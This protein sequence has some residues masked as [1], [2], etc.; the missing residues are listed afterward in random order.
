[1][2]FNR[3]RTVLFDWGN[4]LMHDDPSQST[5]MSGWPQ[6]HMVAGADTLLASLQERGRQLALATGALASDEQEIRA[7]LARVQLDHYM[8]K[9]YCHSTTGE[10]KPS[11]AFY[12]YILNDLR[13]KPAEVLMVGDS[14]ESDVLAANL[15]GIAAV[16]YNPHTSEAKNGQLFSTVHTLADLQARFELTN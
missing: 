13:A 16:W 12:K 14:Y 9:I 8:G 2:D 7:A 4:T 11:G 15:L 3:F 10:Y 6:V 5:S 1:M